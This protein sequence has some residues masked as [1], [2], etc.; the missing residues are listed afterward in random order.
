MEASV[1]LGTLRGAA[2]IL[3]LL[4]SF[5]YVLAI[6]WSSVEVWR[7]RG[8]SPSILWLLPVVIVVY[9][10]STSPPIH[11]VE[12]TSVGVAAMVL[13]AIDI[14]L[15]LA[16]CLVPWHLRKVA[17]QRKTPQP[18]MPERSASDE[19]P[20][21]TPSEATSSD[22]PSRVE[23]D[24][25]PQLVGEKRLQA[26]AREVLSEA[27]LRLLVSKAPVVFFALDRDG[28]FTL[29]EGRQLELLGL[30]PGEVVGFSAFDIYADHPDI[31]SH[32]RAGLAGEARHWVGQVGKL[33]FETQILPLR[34]DDGT[35]DGLI[36][37]A[38]DITEHKFAEAAAQASETKFSSAFDACPD[39][40][41]IATLPEGR[42][43]EVNAGFEKV[44]GYS[45]QEVLGRTS[46]E[47]Q[48]W[49]DPDQRQIFQQAMTEDGR[50]EQFETVFRMSSGELRTCLISAQLFELEGEECAV[51]VVHDITARKAAEDAL[52]RSEGRLAS[53][54]RAIPDAIAISRL[55]G[56]EILDINSGFTELT[57]YETNEALGKNGAELSLWGDLEERREILERIGRQ[58]MLAAEEV[59][60]QRKDGE[61]RWCRMSAETLTLA[62]EPSLLT[63]LHDVTEQR[64][65][66]AAL[67]ASE[68]KFATAF[69]SSPDAIL[70]TS[71]P[72]GRILEVNGGFARVSGLRREEV[73]GV[74]TLE[75]DIWA[76]PELREDMLSRIRDSGR[77]HDFE[78]E[79]RHSDGRL[80][81]CVLFAERVFV[82]GQPC[83]LSVVRDVTERRQAERA[84]RASETRLI[85]AFRAS[86]D[87]ILISRLPEG[88]LLEV[89]DSFCRMT[90][91]SREQA[92]GKTTIELGLHK[93]SVERERLMELLQREKRVQNLETH[94]Y[95]VDGGFHPALV[96]VE[97]IEL[98]GDA[99]L[100]SVVRDMTQ[101]RQT[102]VSRRRLVRMT[103]AISDFVAIG[104][105]DGRLIYLNSGGRKMVGLGPEA[106]ITTYHLA[107]FHMSE[108]AS[109]LRRHVLPQIE[110]L[111]VWGG[112]SIMVSADGRRIPALQVVTHH[113][114][115][116]PGD[117]A[118]LSAICHDI[119]ERKRIE[120]ALVSSEERF[121][122]AFHASPDAILLTSMPSDTILEV[123]QGFSLLTGYS[124][125]DVVGRPTTQLVLWQDLE[126]RQVI[127]DQLSEDG[128]VKDREVEV[129]SRDG[130][131]HTC[132]FTGEVIELGSKP[133]L[134]LML[135][136]V[137]EKRLAEAERDIFIEELEAKNAELERFTY[138][139]SHDLKSP[140]V[141]IKGF[142]GLLR[143]D[144]ESGAVERAGRD[145]DR[146]Q[147][148]ADTM[149]S[150]LDELLEL[151][152]V[153]RVVHPAEHVDL[154]ELARE[155]TELLAGIV[156][157]RHVHLDIAEDLPV[158]YG[159][160]PRLREVVQNLLDNAIKFLGDD[161]PQ[162]RIEMGSEL[163][164][165]EQVIFVRDN[166][167]GI[168][169]RYH[170]KV[171]ELFD[172]LDPTIEGTGIGLAL[173]KRIVEFHQ[174]KVWVE[175]LG[176][177]HG[178]TFCFTLGV[179]APASEDE[180]PEDDA[181]AAEVAPK[182]V[183]PQGVES[184]LDDV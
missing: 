183:S 110:T 148:A 34:R 169:P 104:N 5:L 152:R 79:V 30:E 161:N 17:L 107:D 167:V 78:L 155:V 56:G 64:R 2:A 184:P 168:D 84:L 178:T 177:G 146:I 74:T 108:E 139:V 179:M 160:R 53:A 65:S 135:R 24:L 176:L 27:Q 11:A 96:A 170:S 171:F 121:S 61:L 77:V 8:R 39:S 10:G 128:Q 14:L 23:G 6:G 182:D 144:L 81:E 103:E 150:L 172:R 165:G 92:L 89:N 123:N 162:P 141:T 29:S 158:V 16:S 51:S 67:R 127:M 80:R 63:V 75:L 133:C 28:V 119:T 71:I 37:V 38:N 21:D 181:T 93:D 44:T 145:L 154:G 88:R 3:R 22:L 69:R 102:E 76:S 43:L 47:I 164:D 143:R 117:D 85:T 90:G 126:A 86:P 159:D 18:A 180:M 50:L 134:L 48:L 41:V 58:G 129:R 175:S 136:D 106:D 42:I 125:G 82:Q 95:S 99:A 147:K 45:R 83:L 15:A 131:I 109:W 120:E 157:G 87:A 174:G 91:F 72:E 94:F 32:L 49:E 111:G 113:A 149:G 20:E 35:I 19:S 26:A 62:G 7:L 70:I 151:S 163:R 68:E 116:D 101:Q 166:G 25:K 173:V 9:R 153:G 31:P 114:A 122:K 1:L 13:P 57:G 98:E 40:I 66:E 118:F 33:F 138:T 124:R 12:V 132:M 140:L 105:L 54:F 137:T 156:T 59:T 46:N 4:S 100:L 73:L 60:L 52:R 97:L 112:E 130:K 36:G 55:P 115:N 142:V